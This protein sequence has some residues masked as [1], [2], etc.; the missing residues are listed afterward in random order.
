MLD[1]R[2]LSLGTSKGSC[3][4]DSLERNA[5]NSEIGIELQAERA[6]RWQSPGAREL[7]ND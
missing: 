2:E 4:D 6:D 1:P 3:I 5:R 7:M